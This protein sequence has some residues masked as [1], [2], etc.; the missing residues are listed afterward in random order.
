MDIFLFDD[1]KT[2]LKKRVDSEKDNWGLWAKLAKAANCQATYLSSAI[3][4]KVHLT[5]EH[6][7]GI[8]QFWKLSENETD[9]FLFLLEYNKAGTKEL[10]NY[11]KNK[12]QKIKHEYENLGSRLKLPKL[13]I[14]ARENIY[15]SAWYWSALHVI[16]S[17]P[18]YQTTHAIAHRLLLPIDF[19]EQALKELEKLD[20]VG[21]DGK[22]WKMK[23][24][25]LHIPKNSLMIG[26]HHNNWRQKAVM[27]ST[28]SN[29]V[30]SHSSIPHSNSVHYTAVYS[31]SKSDYQHLKDKMRDLIE[32]SRKLVA[33]SK[34]EELVCF[35]CDL[36]PA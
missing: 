32:H 22:K 9:Y 5:A 36:F 34:E 28:M 23:T 12:I 27:N 13:E 25:D 21:F 35:T 31:L 11:F 30:M 3:K 18:E 7:L 26:I 4:G 1:Y 29:F 10:K 33:P 15:Y 24:A 6:I 20:I 8:S 2:Y 14:G 19:V 16:V 17:I